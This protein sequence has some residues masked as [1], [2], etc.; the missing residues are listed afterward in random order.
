LV[1]GYLFYGLVYLGFAVNNRPEIFWLL[2]GIYGLY[3]GF[4]E[5]VEKALVADIA[6]AGLRATTIGL[7]AAFVGIGLLPASLLAGLL[8]KSFGP[9]APFYFGGIMGLIASAGLWFIL[10]ERN[11]V[12]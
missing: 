8:W 10:K 6:P 3:T 5:G 11:T 9:Q 7:H 4:T 1:L 12:L 2:F